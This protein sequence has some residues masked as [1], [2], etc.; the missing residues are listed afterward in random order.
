MS[1]PYLHTESEPVHQAGRDVAATAGNWQSW[2]TTASVAFTDAADAARNF[3]IG[4]AFGAYGSTW[5][6]TIARLAGEVDAL[7]GNV[8]TASTVVEQA[9][10][11]GA[12]LL[13]TQHQ[14]GGNLASSLRRE[15]NFAV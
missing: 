6:P 15:I 7:G 14:H 11:D 13:H 9:D 12:H 8:S 4:S 3:A 1:P 2:A 10:D 5:N